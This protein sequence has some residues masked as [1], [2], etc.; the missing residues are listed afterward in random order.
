MSTINTSGLNTQYPVAGVNQSSQGFRDNF[1][2]IK[3]NLDTAATE[4]T[5]LQNKVILKSA[6]NGANLDNN[7]AGTIIR[8]AQTQG[9]RGTGINLGTNVSGAVIIDTNVADVYFGTITNDV[10]LS[11][12]KWAPAGTQAQVRVILTAPNSG[13]IFLPSEVDNS[14]LTIEGIGGTGNLTIVPQSATNPTVDLIFSTVDCGTTITVTPV[15]KPRIAEQVQFRTPNPAGTLGDF[16]GSIAIGSNVLWI[17]SGSYDGNT[18]IWTPV[19][20][21]SQGAG[22]VATAT[23]GSG[24]TAGKVVSMSLTANGSGYVNAPI[25]SFVS[26]SGTGAAATAVLGSG[27][28]SGQVINLIVTNGGSG[29]LTEPTVVFTPSNAGSG[30]GGTTLDNGGSNIDV[31]F[32]GNIT[33]TANNIP[34]VFTAT[35][36]SVLIGKAADVGNG[37][38]A[39]IANL[40]VNGNARANNFTASNG[41]S[42]FGNLVVST[43]NSASAL[44]VSNISNVIISNG[45]ITTVG[46]VSVGTNLSVTGNATVTGNIAITSNAAVTGILTVTGNASTANLV[47]NGNA[48]ITSNLL[49][50]AIVS[51]TTV[52]GNIITGASG[53]IRI[54]AT[55]SNTVTVQASSSTSSSFSLTLPPNDG[56]AGQVLTTDGS[57]IL[58]WSAGGGGGSGGFTNIQV[59]TSTPASPWTIPAG[60]TRAKV[61]VVGG[62]AG[63]GNSS[64]G[65]TLTPVLGGGGG[66]GGAAIDILTGLTPGGT[67]SITVGAGGAGGTSSTAPVAGTS[68]SAGAITAS[69]GAVGTNSQL[70][71]LGGL[72]VTIGGANI[73]GGYGGTGTTLVGSSAG[74]GGASIYGGGGAGGI[75]SALGTNGINGQAPGSGGGAAGYA[76]GTGLSKNGGAGANGIVIIEY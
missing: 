15:N 29:Y 49:A 1:N 36:T 53:N 25:V 3:Q 4:I 34:N 5:D 54:R 9:F 43:V 48:N 68:S 42:M 64:L 10:T 19:G 23:L 61:T 41:V 22:A 30:G 7:M 26:T 69:G 44:N 56:T 46:A 63:G 12:T 71:G 51:N 72:G 50:N 52:T 18:V 8:N 37:I 74:S 2:N 28:N 24:P 20:T 11:F 65:S 21:T 32:N 14:R 73:R 17:C 38:P 59:F 70:G 27:A 58:S 62:G 16:A 55:G 6:L 31:G 57:G 47:V 66:A 35:G 45:N 40:V 76:S 33:M 13:N 60:I 75:A 67:L 39:T